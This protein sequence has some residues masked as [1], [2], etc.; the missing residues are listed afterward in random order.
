[1]ATW[2]RIG[3]A[4]FWTLG[5]M[6]GGMV[7]QRVFKAALYPLIDPN[8][9]FSTPAVWLEQLVPVLFVILGMGI[10]VWVIAGAVQ[11]ERGVDRRRVRR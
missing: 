3:V 8:G 4:L 5:L 9:T 11:D 2:Q 10:W 6:V 7:Y 1:M